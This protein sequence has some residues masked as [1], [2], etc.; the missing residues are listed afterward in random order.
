MKEKL[1]CFV[2]E[3]GKDHQS[4]SFI[5]AV[6]VTGKERDSLLKLCESFEKS[7]RKGK[8]K[9][10]RAKRNRSL[11]YFRAIL[12]DSRFHNAL[13]YAIFRKTTDHDS[14]TIE[15]IA[16]ALHW[17]H[18]DDYTATIYVDAL[19]KTKCREYSIRLRRLGAS[20]EKQVR[21]VRKDENNALIRLANDV[22]GFVRDIKEGQ[23]GE[24]KT[25]F[26]EA[27]RK[28]FFIEV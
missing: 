22:A 25:V 20:L 6:V 4:K 18:P 11:A 27:Q 2:D 24:T 5:V 13:R 16:R 10:G 23:S 7:T 1:Y 14:A 15:G 19:A 12:A 26:D 21:G 17:K 8:F 9:W 28:G 3:T